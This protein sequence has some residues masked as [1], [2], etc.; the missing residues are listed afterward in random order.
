MNEIS[1]TA[2]PILLLTSNFY[3]GGMS[4]PTLRRSGPASV[5]VRWLSGRA[6]QLHATLLAVGAGCLYAG[7][8]ELSRARSGNELS[9]VYVFEWPFFAAFAAVIWWRSL[10][11]GAEGAENTEA[12][13]AAGDRAPVTEARTAD[14]AETSAR[15]ARAPGDSPDGGDEQLRAWQDYVARLNAQHPPGGPPPRPARRAGGPGSTRERT[16]R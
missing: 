13:G 1:W 3:A 9:W 8:F 4:N 10:H 14:A 16:G 7:W 5:P 12:A 11:E 2:R 15:P 6:L